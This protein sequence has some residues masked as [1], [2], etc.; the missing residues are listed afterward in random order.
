MQ[1][2]FSAL[3]PKLLVGKSNSDIEENDYFWHSFFLLKPEFQVL[4]NALFSN[5]SIDSLRSLIT[6]CLE[7]IA[8]QKND[9]VTKMKKVNASLLL[10]QIFES[11]WPRIRAGTFG[12]DAINILCGLQNADDFFEKLFNSILGQDQPET[13]LV[14]LSLLVATRDI[15]TN[16]LTDFFISKNDKIVSFCIQASDLHILLF[17]LLLQLERPCG[18]FAEVFMDQKK[19]NPEKFR[20]L[21]AN[22]LARCTQFY[23][24]CR[25][26]QKSLFRKVS[27]PTCAR[28]GLY[29]PSDFELPGY[30]QLFEPFVDAAALNFLE[31][32]MSE[33]DATT[34]SAAISLFTHVETSPTTLH[35]GDRLYLFLIA[36]AFL[37][38][39]TPQIAASHFDHNQFSSCF[40]CGVTQCVER[41]IGAMIIECLCFAL[42]LKSFLPKL[43]NIVGRIIYS[44]IFIFNTYR[45]TH[46]V[47]W[48]KMFTS[49]FHAIDKGTED[50]QEF[51]T[52]V[53]ALIAMCSSFRTALFKRDDGYIELLRALAANPSPAHCTCAPTD[54]FE[55]SDEFIKVCQSHVKELA[56]V[57]MAIT[58]EMTDEQVYEFAQNL[59]INTVPTATFKVPEQLTEQPRFTQFLRVYERTH[60]ENIQ[61][62]LH[63]AARHN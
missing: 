40:N 55:R 23:I 49:L 25:P 1:T 58:P 59:K 51:N 56:E 61:A 10:V 6:K 42:D 36:F 44:I 15:E 18:P 43:M 47:E 14:L 45:G 37:I 2:K 3:V 20:P 63:F 39:K 52:F 50:S 27:T 54:A 41:S 17:S 32:A 11:L 62:F 8:V 19:H 46:Q 24:C 48:K 5:Y 4:Q 34:V 30:F 38:C 9:K 60:C 7:T 21:V 53:V 31:L 16:A 57:T 33:V 35:S 28:I 26:V 12:V 13:V 22:L 29:S